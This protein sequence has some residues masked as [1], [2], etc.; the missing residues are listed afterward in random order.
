MRQIGL[1]D[2]AQEANRFTAY[3]IVERIRAMVE[4][5]GEKFA[6]WVREENDLARA[7]DESS[8]FIANPADPR[9][10][11][12]EREA[13]AILKNERDYRATGVK[14]I[15]EPKKQSAPLVLSRRSP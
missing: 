14:N 1:L 4:Q 10:Q 3:L 11:N 7:K 13:E 5:E 2:S 15:I 6:V 12:K 8:S 9:Y